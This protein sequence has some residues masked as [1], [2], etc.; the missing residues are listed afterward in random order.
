MPRSKTGKIRPPIDKKNLS[1]AINAILKEGMSAYT[2][3]KV[4]NLSKTTL[5]RHF[6]DHQRSE[7]EQFVYNSRSQWRLVFSLEEELSLAE[8]LITASK[9]HYGLTRNA[10]M[11]FAY[12]F[13]EK[14]G[15]IC[16]IH[17][18]NRKQ[19]EKCG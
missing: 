3:A 1:D 2:A 12:Q 18:W 9:L 5:L 15:R 8:Y 17:G 14:T 10:T 6:K 13:A 4:F 11:R 7:S 19:L 16:L